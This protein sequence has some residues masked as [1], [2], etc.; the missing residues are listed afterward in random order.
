MRGLADEARIRRFMR[1]LALAARL[2]SS[3]LH[4]TFEA[5]EPWLYRYPAIDPASFRRA[6]DAFAAET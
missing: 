6:V 3:D 4:A 5:I 1:E 2:T